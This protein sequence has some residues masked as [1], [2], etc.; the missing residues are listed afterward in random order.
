MKIQLRLN[1]VLDI[2]KKYTES[3]LDYY[4]I[5]QDLL[6]NDKTIS[7]EQKNKLMAHALIHNKKEYKI[8]GVSF[9]GRQDKLFALK[10]GEVLFLEKQPDNEYDP[11]AVAVKNAN[12]AQIG[13]LPAILALKLKNIID[14]VDV[15]ISTIFQSMSNRFGGLRVK[16]QP[17]A[18][19]E[20][21]NKIELE[22]LLE[23]TQVDDEQ[24]SNTMEQYFS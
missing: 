20:V 15:K 21:I 5:A 23:T 14:Y 1:K 17:K 2:I 10:E 3:E 8:V 4:D 16:F 7:S 12:G 9:E 18:T 24:I 19:N 13:F 22:L 11:N 6:E